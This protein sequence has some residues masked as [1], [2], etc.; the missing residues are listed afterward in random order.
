MNLEAV[1][2]EDLVSSYLYK[3]STGRSILLKHLL[4]T[5]TLIRWVSI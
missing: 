2:Q 5:S 3:S 1:I 4:H